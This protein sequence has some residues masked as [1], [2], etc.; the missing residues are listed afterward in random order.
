MSKPAE[1]QKYQ[2]NS[3]VW[4]WLRLLSKASH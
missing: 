2:P 3:P 1:V 4:S